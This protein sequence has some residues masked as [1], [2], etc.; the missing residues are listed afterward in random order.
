MGE[1]NSWWK[2]YGELW[3]TGSMSEEP[4]TVQAMWQK[5]MC[6]A[7]LR[8]F[9]PRG[10]ISLLGERGMSDTS[11]SEYCKVSRRFWGQCKQHFIDMGCIT[12]DS[13]GV[14][15]VTNWHKYQPD[16]ERQK[17]YRVTEM[18]DNPKSCNRNA[19][20]TPNRVI[21]MQEKPNFSDMECKKSD[22]SLTSDAKDQADNLHG[23]YNPQAQATSDGVTTEV[24]SKVTGMVTALDSR[25]ETIDTR[26]KS[27][28]G[29]DVPSPSSPLSDLLVLFSGL[30]NRDP[31]SIELVDLEVWAE[32]YRRKDLTYAFGEAK[33]LGKREMSY[34]ARILTRLSEEKAQHP[35]GLERF[36]GGRYGHVVQH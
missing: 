11:M 25:V 27:R 33:R 5:V 23:D 4:L 29:D 12:I 24:T 15:H 17:P 36:T 8:K 14:I 26:L 28:E 30:F 34:M 3:L 19:S 9:G 16:Y 31:S 1:E 18:Q 10:T 20:K 7:S 21:E 13:S 32:K 2:C 35:R 6:L 22:G